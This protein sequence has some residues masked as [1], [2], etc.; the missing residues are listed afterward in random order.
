MLTV[1]LD[2]MDEEKPPTQSISELELIT[3][4]GSRIQRQESRESS[5]T[6][7]DLQTFDKD[8]TCHF[9]P[10]RRVDTEMGG[11]AQTSGHAD[12]VPAQQPQRRST[13]NPS[14]G[15]V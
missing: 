12:G 5:E 3:D 6:A 11:H 9:I 7:G 15:V 13:I 2:Q 8:D 14:L 4:Y 1:S 10:P